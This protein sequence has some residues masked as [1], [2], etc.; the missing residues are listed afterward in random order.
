MI[1]DRGIIKW[2]P[3]TMPEQ[4]KMLA[5]MYEA[6]N[7]IKQPILE[8]Q[9]LSELDDRLAEAIHDNHTVKMSYY[10]NKRIRSILGV[11]SKVDPIEGVI[12][13]T[14]TQGG[15]IRVSYRSILDLECVND[16]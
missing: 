9:M 15:V 12:H 16:K 3:F 13:I 10:E 4:R 8:E 11:I 6:G 2:A 14:A 7:D 5:K 1:R